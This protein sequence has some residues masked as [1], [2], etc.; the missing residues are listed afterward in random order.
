MDSFVGFGCNNR[1]V[2]ETGS[3]FAREHGTPSSHILGQNGRS[4]WGVCR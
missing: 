4:L 2:D 1:Y 3:G